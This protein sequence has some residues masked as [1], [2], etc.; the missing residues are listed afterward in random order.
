M[1]PNSGQ[2][3][4]W[5]QGESALAR[6]ELIEDDR[7]VILE[8]KQDDRGAYYWGR[9]EP[10]A[11]PSSDPSSAAS[12]K[13]SPA[14]DAEDAEEE[15]TDTAAKKPREVKP[16]FFLS[17]DKGKELVAKVA[18][19]RAQRLIGEVPADR[20]P[21]FGL[22]KPEGTLA[23][24]V[25]GVR[26]EFIIGSSAPGSASQYFRY[27]QDN[28]VYTLDANIV[29]ELRGAESSLRQRLQHDFKSADVQSAT[30]RAGESSR[31]VVR[32]GTEG[33]RFWANEKTPD[34]NDEMTLNWLKKLDRLYPGK[35]VE[36]MP[37]GAQLIVRVEYGREGQSLGFAELH[38]V[39]DDKKGNFYLKTETLRLPATVSESD[40]QQVRNELKSVL[41]R[42]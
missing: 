42:P 38:H 7:R 23:I 13:P 19:M 35:F 18:P 41:E 3:E 15:E 5:K 28:L 32:V 26:H 11:K 29:E 24:E 36:A 2:V 1:L 21:V 30:I 34:V 6:I 10:T 9:V 16:A 40:A 33:R 8:R 27:K 20:E 37:E 4:L 39:P 25:G 12:S 22:D 17:V 14:E 31:T